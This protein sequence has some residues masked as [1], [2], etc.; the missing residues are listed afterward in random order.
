MEMTLCVSIPALT[1][2]PDNVRSVCAHLRIVN[3]LTFIFLSK[4]TH[5]IFTKAEMNR[6]NYY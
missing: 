1:D 3:T 2:G 4:Q 6:C 5:V